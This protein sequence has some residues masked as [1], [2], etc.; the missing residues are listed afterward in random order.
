MLRHMPLLRDHSPKINDEDP[1]FYDYTMDRSVA[2]RS[3]RF[4]DRMHAVGHRALVP[5]PPDSRRW[6]E[7]L[8]QVQ[9]EVYVESEANN[10]AAVLLR[11]PEWRKR[12]APIEEI[13]SGAA[14]AAP[15]AGKGPWAFL[16]IGQPVDYSVV[17]GDPWT[18]P[19]VSSEQKDNLTW[20]QMDQ[21]CERVIRN[22]QRFE[23]WGNRYVRVPRAVQYDSIVRNLRSVSMPGG[24]TVSI[25]LNSLENMRS[26]ELG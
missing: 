19:L 13:A 18:S 6:L 10:G 7:R 2:A 23:A 26:Q 15:G 21:V 11:N 5:S 8:R 22:W 24:G 20:R 14:S 16:V 9:E 3:L 4:G 12:L 17:P 25:S 1:G